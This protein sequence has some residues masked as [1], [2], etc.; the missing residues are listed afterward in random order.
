MDL[1]LRLQVKRRVDHE[2]RLWRIVNAAISAFAPDDD[3]GFV[4]QRLVV[5][6]YRPVG[7]VHTIL[8]GGGVVAKALTVLK[9]CD[10]APSRV[11]PLS[12]IPARPSY[13]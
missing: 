10:F 1:N 7:P 4:A 6:T 5:P 11:S 12:H 2:E 9:S 3:T 13:F 8:S